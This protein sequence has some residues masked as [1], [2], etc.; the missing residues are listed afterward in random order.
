M[1]NVKT[2]LIDPIQSKADRDFKQ[3][4]IQQSTEIKKNFKIEVKKA[5]PSHYGKKYVKFCSGITEQG[6]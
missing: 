6:I 3:A 5:L 2:L 1:I 4:H